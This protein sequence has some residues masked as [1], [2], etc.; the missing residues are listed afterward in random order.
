[1][2]WSNPTYLRSIGV[3]VGNPDCGYDG[4]KQP[5]KYRIIGH[6]YIKESSTLDLFNYLNVGLLSDWLLTSTLKLFGQTAVTAFHILSF[7]NPQSEIIMGHQF[8][9]FILQEQDVLEE[10]QIFF[11][12]SGFIIG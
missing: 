1:L 9:V 12:T 5:K 2:A 10:I 4:P 8:G 11:A 3:P 7:L 6:D